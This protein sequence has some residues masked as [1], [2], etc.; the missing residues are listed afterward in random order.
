LATHPLSRGEGNSLV[1]AFPPRISHST[2]SKTPK[3]TD[4][5]AKEIGVASL[6]S[7]PPLGALSFILQ[8]HNI[9]TSASRQR[10]MS[11]NGRSRIFQLFKVT[12]NFTQPNIGI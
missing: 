3:S 8:E 12:Y 1:R 2:K 9:S 11:N 6:P 5:S 4:T 10:V 7:A